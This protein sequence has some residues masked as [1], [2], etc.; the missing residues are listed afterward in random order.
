MNIYHYIFE[1][2]H[3]KSIFDKRQ[4]LQPVLIYKTK[5]KLPAQIQHQLI[6]LF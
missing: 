4:V 6:L 2:Q 3:A 1:C 5:D